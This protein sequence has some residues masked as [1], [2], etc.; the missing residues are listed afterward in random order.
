MALLLV[1]LQLRLQESAHASHDALAGTKTLHQYDEVV[2]VTGEAMAA[3]L[4]RYAWRRIPVGR[5]GGPV[6]VVVPVRYAPGLV[7][8]GSERFEPS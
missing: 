1:H 5:A 8:F 3:P 6:L 7:A 2:R 4:P